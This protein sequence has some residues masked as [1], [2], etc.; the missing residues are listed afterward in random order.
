MAEPLHLSII[1]MLDDPDLCGPFFQNA[2][3]K[4]SRAALSALFGLPMDAVV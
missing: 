4:P 2:S 1:D 3:W